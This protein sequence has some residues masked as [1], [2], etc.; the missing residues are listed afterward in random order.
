VGRARSRG[1]Q[2]RWL[3]VAAVTAEQVAQTGLEPTVAELAELLELTSAH[4]KEPMQAAAGFRAVSLDVANA[5]LEQ[6]AAV[7]TTA[8]SSEERERWQL[9]SALIRRLP[10]RDR[11]VL[12]LRY[13][14]DMTQRAIAA[15]V[16]VSQ[17]HV[18]RILSRSIDRLNREIQPAA[19]AVR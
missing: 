4:V 2:E 10:E 6:M 9:A 11:R 14:D 1:L 12:Y 19:R 3:A 13:F 15:S 16:G 8:E 5:E 7:E 17:M 18:S